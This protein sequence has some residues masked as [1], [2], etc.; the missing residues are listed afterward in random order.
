MASRGAKVSF[1]TLMPLREMKVRSTSA[2]LPPWLNTMAA[3]DLLHQLPHGVVAMS[4]DIEDLVE[5][6]VN[7]ATME[8][9]KDVLLV[10][11]SGRS[12]AGEELDKVVERVRETAEERGCKFTKGDGYPGWTP[13]LDSPLL[14]VIVEQHTR[15]FDKP[16][17]V[18][19][20]HAGLECGIIGEKFPGMD[21]VAVGPQLEHPHSPE[22]RVDVESV[23]RVWRLVLAVLEQR[24][25]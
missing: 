7:L 13:N 15:L 18:K 11:M 10:G 23:E 1:S 20:I 4:K 22:E 3:V 25:G 14:K 17:E 21:M 9:E 8:T 12:S 24:G 2:L 16:P 5:T 19:A 6:S